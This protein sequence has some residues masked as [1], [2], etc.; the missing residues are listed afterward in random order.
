MSELGT[1]RRRSREDSTCTVQTSG[2]KT[3]RP[4]SRL[5][6][7]SLRSALTTVLD[8]QNLPAIRAYGSGTTNLTTANQHTSRFNC[9]LPVVLRS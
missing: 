2:G 6:M 4:S 5:K 8:G 7:N 3:M 1:P 9:Q